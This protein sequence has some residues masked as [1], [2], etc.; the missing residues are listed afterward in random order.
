[1]AVLAQL[2]LRYRLFLSYAVVLLISLS[3]IATALLFFL[4]ARPSPPESTYERLAA[5]AQGLNI[6]SLVEEFAPTLGGRPIVRLRLTDLLGD[7]A[8]TRGVRVMSITIE[9]GQSIVNYDSA[10]TF[11]VGSPIDIVLG[12]YNSRRLAR[13][14]GAGISQVYG[15]FLDPTDGSEWLFGGIGGQRVGQGYSMLILADPRP[16]I[17]LQE[18]LSEFG[19]SLL[20]PILQAGCVGLLVAFVLAAVI[21]RSIARP[22]QA[23]AKAA[24]EVAAGR[25]E[26]RVPVSGPPEVRAVAEAFNRMS[27]EVRL[28]QQA[29]RDFLANVSHDLKTPLTSIQG[30]SQAIIDGAAKNPSH[31]AE[32]IHDEAERLNR[33]VVELTD[34][35]RIQAGRLSMKTAAVDMGQVVAAICQR[36]MVVA[37]KKRITLHVQ[38]SRMPDI[39]GD[40]DRLAQ[41]LTNLVS[42][43]IKYT[44]EGGEIW[45]TTQVVGNGVEV[46]VKDNG[47]GIPQKDLPRI[48][49]RFY[50]VDKSRGPERGT[51]LGLAIVREIVQAHG[52]EIRVYSEGEGKGTTFVVWLPS[53]YLSTVVSRKRG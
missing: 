46:V 20:L 39:A 5:V 16:S 13:V 6:N 11:M 45:V 44:P 35:A 3:V 7:F 37:Q 43:A 50:Q 31:A 24:P 9:G 22:L 17:S 21:S 40:G 1:M 51:G 23:V 33:M 36:L 53:P 14:V 25:Y 15:S 8:Q 49:E 30:Y 27:E 52:G 47:I 42:N 48:F 41:V 4:A 18:T 12:S 29:Q 2:S 28:T 38:A 34:L 32:I 19:S 26:L 10:K